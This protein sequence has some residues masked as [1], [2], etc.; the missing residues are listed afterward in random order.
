MD[1]RAGHLN[2]K[3]FCRPTVSSRYAFKR[4]T[5]VPMVN[6]IQVASQVEG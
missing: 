1:S 2:K 3:N 5:S 4:K 6:K